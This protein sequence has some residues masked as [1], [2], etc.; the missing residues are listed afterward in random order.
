MLGRYVGASGRTQVEGE[1]LFGFPALRGLSV[2]VFWEWEGLERCGAVGWRWGATVN[3]VASAAGTSSPQDK[4]DLVAQL[5]QFGQCLQG[6]FFSQQ[7]PLCVTQLL[8]Q[9][10]TACLTC[11]SQTHNNKKNS[12]DIFQ[13]AKKKKQQ[14]Q[15]VVN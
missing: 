11:Q 2:E 1:G 14:K 3:V 12:K 6:T 4:L 13:A 9:D 5:T 10:I 8:D 15:A 7:L